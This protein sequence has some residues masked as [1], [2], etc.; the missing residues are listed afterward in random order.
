M[1]TLLLLHAVKSETVAVNT[2]GSSIKQLVKGDKLQVSIPENNVAFVV[3]SKEIESLN[4]DGTTVSNDDKSETRAFMVTGSSL[5][6]NV[7]QDRVDA[8]I[9]LLPNDRCYHR[10]FWASGENYY[11]K[12]DEFDAADNICFFPVSHNHASIISH[13]TSGSES[14]VYKNADEYKSCNS[15]ETCYSAS[16]R[17]MFI[18]IPSKSNKFTC[19]YTSH[20]DESF[21]D[22]HFGF[23][24]TASSQGKAMNYKFTEIV[25]NYLDNAT[26]LSIVFGTLGIVAFTTIWIV[27]VTI[28]CGKRCACCHCCCCCRS[29]HNIEASNNENN[30]TRHQPDVK[31]DA[32]YDQSL[33]NG[34]STQKSYP[35]VV[36]VYP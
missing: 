10:S 18:Q 12:A 7:D 23:F 24:A 28:I 13:E 27:T 9:W 6:Y 31:V 3:F 17:P 4:I 19:R 26:L 32:I 36:A 25:Y 22:K 29:S 20:Q 11:I 5:E 1:F 21:S 15:G 30:Y 35:N 14:K 34:D 16:E 33:Y 8:Y 2:P